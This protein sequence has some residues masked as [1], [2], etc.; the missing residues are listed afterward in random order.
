MI[1]TAASLV[2]SLL[3]KRAPNW[4]PNC[5]S[6]SLAAIACLLL[7]VHEPELLWKFMQ[8]LHLLFQGCKRFSCPH[9]LLQSA[10][11]LDLLQNTL[12]VVCIYWRWSCQLT[13]ASLSGSLL[14]TKGQLSHMLVQVWTVMC[15]IKIHC[16]E[17]RVP[18]QHPLTSSCK[19]VYKPF[20]WQF[21]TS[22]KKSNSSRK[23][24]KIQKHL[25]I[26]ADNTAW[27]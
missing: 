1:I 25:R 10:L 14:L 22:A 18:H 5:H 3:T 6:L 9:A 21:A 15:K 11:N 16:L 17:K 8:N 13:T 7:C 19:H 2:Q 4:Q 23:G 12:T 24:V 26:Q 20:S 27:S